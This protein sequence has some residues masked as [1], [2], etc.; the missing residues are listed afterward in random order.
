MS[1]IA[2]Q[3]IS[4]GPAAATLP[5]AR[6]DTDTTPTGSHTTSG[7]PPY[8]LFEKF[9]ERFVFDTSSGHFFRV[10]RLAYRFLEL[11]PG[12]SAEEVRS[13]LIEHEGHSA[14][15]VDAV[16]AEAAILAKSG[17][18]DVPNY[19]PTPAEIEAHLRHRYETPWCRLE[20]ALAETCN[21]ACSYCYCRTC[22][23]RENQGLMSE[24]VARQAITWLF[25]MSGCEKEV[26][27]TFFGGEP[28]LNKSVLC[29]CIEYSQRLAKLHGKTVRYVMTTNGTLLDDE[30]IGYIKRY[31]FGLMVS[32]DGPQE[33]HDAQCPRKNGGG[34][35][36]DAERGIK[37]LMRRRRRVTVRCTRT[38]SA[39]PATELIDFFERFGFT[40]I[41]L[42]KTV[43]PVRPSPVDCREEDLHRF[44]EEEEAVLPY[45]FGQLAKGEVPKYFP[46]GRFIYEQ[47][48][49]EPLPPSMFRCG[50]CRGTTTVGADGTLYPCPRFVGMSS[51]IIGEVSE[52]PQIGTAKQFWRD[53]FEIRQKHCS[54]CW[55]RPLCNGPCPWEIARADG[56]FGQPAPTEC[57]FVQG[58]LERAAWVH[59]KVETDFPEVYRTLT[60]TQDSDDSEP[61]TRTELSDLGTGKDKRD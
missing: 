1:Q 39:P 19:D 38:R 53:Y 60:N 32:L 58:F 17:M 27:I 36:T 12:H 45:I 22:P 26:E 16:A 54:Q 34:S 4:V 44:D 13:L 24:N 41:L 5:F 51:F 42:G 35:F 31:N 6:S 29:F 18:F 28:L 14:E 30:V 2:N 21:L 48:Q 20:L 25:A 59:W 33:V 37:A 57:K 7:V 10:D 49:S 15:T 43:N 8:H 61:G 52:G 23:D 40:R 56:T 47:G 9:G 3:P 55:A 50:A 11:C 46:Y